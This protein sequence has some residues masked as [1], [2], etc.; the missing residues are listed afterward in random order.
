MHSAATVRFDEHL[1]K[2]VNINIIALKDILKMSQ[3]MRN[4][5]VGTARVYCSKNIYIF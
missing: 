4:L 3:E 1:R 5:K 2:A